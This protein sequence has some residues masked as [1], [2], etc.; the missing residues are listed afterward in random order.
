M[1][2][3]LTDGQVNEIE[4][5]IKEAYEEGWEDGYEYDAIYSDMYL[6]WDRSLAKNESCHVVAEKFMKASPMVCVD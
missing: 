6:D 1:F 4:K 5:M 3:N 2:S